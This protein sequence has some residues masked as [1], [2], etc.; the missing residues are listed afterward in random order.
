M[1]V[2]LNV[3]WTLM[4]F[5]VLARMLHFDSN[6]FLN[7]ASFSFRICKT[8]MTSKIFGNKMTYYDLTPTGNN[9]NYCS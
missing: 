4:Q 5:S 8:A 6:F 3:R 7:V 2:V 1:D 9:K